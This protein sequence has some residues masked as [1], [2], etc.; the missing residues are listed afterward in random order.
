VFRKQTV[1]DSALLAA[2]ELRRIF[3]DTLYGREIA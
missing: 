1:S 2:N 3:A